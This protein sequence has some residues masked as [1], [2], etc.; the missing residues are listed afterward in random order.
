MKDVFLKAC[1]GYKGKI[2]LSFV[3][4]YRDEFGNSKQKTIEKLGYLEDLKNMYDD[5]IAHFKEVAK[6]RNA[7]LMSEYTIKNLNTQ[8][9]ELNSKPKNLGY[10]VL[11]KIYKELGLDETLKEEQ[12]KY[13]IEYNLSDI[14][15][16]LVYMR[17]LKPGSKKDNYENKDLLFEN[18]D[19]SLDDIYR[20]LTILSPLKEKIQQVMWEHTKN[21]YKRN[22][23]N[24]YYDCTNYYF[25][26]EYNDEDEY[27][28]DSDG[29]IIKDEKGEP[30]LM[31]PGLRKRGPEKNHRPDPIV[32]MG[33]LMDSSDIPLAYD[34][35]PGNESEKKSLIPIL[36]RTKAD[37]DLGRTIIVANRGLN[38][39][40]NIIHIAGTSI[41]QS[42]KLNGYV[43]GQSVRGADEEFK[44]WVL[45]QDYKT[46]VLID[47][48]AEEV[49]FIHKSRVYPKKMRIV[50]DDKGKTKNGNDKVQYITV[51][52]KQMV[53]Y[54]QKYADKQ[55]RDREKIVAK[56]RDLMSHPDRYTKAT[57]YGVAGYINNLKF[58]K[59]TGE[60]ANAYELTLNEERIKEEEKYDGYYSIV[61]SEEHL[62]D[63][64]IRRIYR[65]LSRIEETFKV[66]KSGLS[67]RPV[68]VS[69]EEHIQS[70]FLTC[71]IALVIV[72][73]LEKRLN[74]KYNF[75]AI[76]NAIRNYTS[77]NIDHDIYLHSFRNEVIDSFEQ[78]FNIEL[79]K[80]FKNLS[81]IKKI[82]K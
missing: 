67:G 50:R 72:R 74:N 73:L 3:Q 81:E 76:I 22:T 23:S 5:P 19:F 66:T 45:E 80:K 69:L 40:D 60:V 38:T 25:E 13:K 42:K 41:E 78:E 39:S 2:Y 29:H 44:A 53:Y 59:S 32:E 9:I 8:T 17:V 33:L 52:Q 20:S 14:L 70:H 35:F 26:V 79:S 34:L 36:K 10:A 28:L 62:S 51:D 54:S 48:N 71:F 24:C 47:D 55:K 6:Q 31:K 11:K 27:E 1:P 82:L 30:V 64:E 37:L 57:S 15:P 43:Y 16:F 63:I 58:V 77:C 4:G 56:A 61:T 75:Q 68:W 21:K 7:E 18:T 65:G 12:S 49:T 46:D